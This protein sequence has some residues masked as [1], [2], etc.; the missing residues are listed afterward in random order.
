MLRPSILLSFALS[1]TCLS[2]N[3]DWDAIADEG[4]TGGGGSTSVAMD[5]STS[6]DP[7][8]TSSPATT[9]TPTPDTTTGEGETYAGSSSTGDMPPQGRVAD[10]LAML[11]TFIFDEPGLVRDVAGI[12]PPLDLTISESST[13][14]WVE[15]GLRIDGSSILTTIPVDASRLATQAFTLELW[16]DSQSTTPALPD[17][18]RIVA[19]EDH[20]APLTNF[21]VTGGDGVIA[22]TV[23]GDESGALERFTL[24]VEP[25]LR[26]VVF[27]VST[28]G[29]V[30]GYEN[31]ELE[32]LVGI[33]EQPLSLW[34]DGVPFVVANASDSGHPWLGTL[35]LLAIYDR[36]LSDDE[37]VRNFEQG[38]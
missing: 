26:H 33:R 6:M 17:G 5:V 38:R 31:G 3:P 15:D 35:G 28:A 8:E 22:L 32:L 25:G 16:V 36:A 2:A 4:S 23:L 37:V 29:Q 20:L 1:G 30:R 21:Y 11:H 12:D 10:G 27:T 19:F 24:D 34:L 7:V 13:T 14:V 9:T 18:P